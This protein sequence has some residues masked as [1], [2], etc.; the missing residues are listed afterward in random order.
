MAD[1]LGIREV[2]VPRFSSSFSAWSMLTLDMGRDYL[3]SYIASAREANVER[4]NQLF[5]DMIKEARE[6]FKALKVP[7][8]EVIYEKSADVRYSGQYHEIE[9]PLPPGEVTPETI[10]AMD[11]EF[12]KR[13]E[14]VF[15]FSMDWVP[16]EIRNLRLI[17]KVRAKEMTLPVLE[18]GGDPSKARKPGRA[19]FFKGQFR[20]TFIYDAARLK[21]GNLVTGPSIVEEPTSTIVVPEGFQ[22][23]ID[24]YGN[25]LLRKI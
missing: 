20:E 25:Y 10:G 21:A 5:E 22:C 8:T 9:M 18:A 24:D 4:I 3:R 23:S 2:V 7:M 19:C 16:P 12:H 17:A 1:L 11:R 13:H 15:T 6:E 14:A